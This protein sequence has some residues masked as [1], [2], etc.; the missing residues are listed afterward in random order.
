MPNGPLLPLLRI[1]E[2][3]HVLEAAPAAVSVLNP[4]ALYLRSSAVTYGPPEL[5]LGHR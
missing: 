3:F 2:D 5:R 4:R 1:R